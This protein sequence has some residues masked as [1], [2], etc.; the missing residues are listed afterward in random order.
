MVNRKIDSKIKA[1]V[2]KFEQNQVKECADMQPAKS[3]DIMVAQSG[4]DMK[5]NPLKITS[6]AQS[7]FVQNKKSLEN[8]IKEQFDHEPCKNSLI[9]DVNVKQLAAQFESYVKR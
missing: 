7:L 6:H 8:P 9:T 1:I 2:E 5:R 4:V 3:K